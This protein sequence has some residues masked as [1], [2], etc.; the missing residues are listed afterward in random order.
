[1]SSGNT[2]ILIFSSHGSHLIWCESSLAALWIIH[3]RETV[4]HDDICQLRGIYSVPRPTYVPWETQEMCWLVAVVPLTC[5]WSSATISFASGSSSKVDKKRL[6]YSFIISVGGVLGGY[7]IIVLVHSAP[8]CGRILCQVSC[9][10]VW[11]LEAPTD[12]LLRRRSTLIYSTIY[13]TSQ[14]RKIADLQI[15]NLIEYLIS[16]GY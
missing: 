5:V 2:N 8:W 13:S 15:L 7:D 3:L 10:R 12:F 9:V 11:E 4:T 1:M 16:Q 14:N 6:V